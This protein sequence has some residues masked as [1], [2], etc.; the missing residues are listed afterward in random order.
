MRLVFMGTP[1][2]AVPS[3]EYLLNKEDINVIAVLTQPDKPAGRGKKLT[4]S[5]IKLLAQEYNIPVFQPKSIR[6]DLDLQGQLINLRP[7]IFITVAFGQILSQEVLD[8]PRIGT[9]NL[10]ASLLPK[11]RGANPI[12]AAIV[13][14]EKVTG[15]TTMLTDIGIDT[16]DML[17][18][19]E[20]EITEDMNSAQLAEKISQIG[21]ELL[22]K[23][24]IGL[25]DKTLNPTPQNHDESTHA[26][27]FKKEDGLIN[28]NLPA[29]KIHNQ[30]R[31]MYPWPSAYTN[32]GQNNLK[33]ISSGLIKSAPSASPGEIIS[34]KKEGVVVAAKDQ[35]I[36]L[37]TLQP[38]G[39]KA[40]DA[41]SWCNGARIKT[42]DILGA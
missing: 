42:G 13:N 23:S 41:Q 16:G 5:P 2:I 11:Y 4:A 27:K 37:K 35:C 9:I 32:I 20:I 29:Q 30:I 7:D 19:E 24:I 34:I 1:Q 14:G 18:K 3:L 15:V 25:N 39:K 38:A 26:P 40:M 17:L 36:L 8:I 6:K 21:P 10:H 33:I 28:W 12:Q 31:G 22:Y